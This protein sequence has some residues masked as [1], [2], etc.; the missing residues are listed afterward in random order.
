MPILLLLTPPILPKLFAFS[1]PLLDKGASKIPNNL[2]S[3]IIIGNF[4][5]SSSEFINSILY[6]N[7]L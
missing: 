7:K 4:I 5:W 2:N 1:I 3:H 6:I